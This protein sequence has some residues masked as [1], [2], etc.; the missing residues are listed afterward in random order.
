[1]EAFAV[2][3]ATGLLP[4]KSGFRQQANFCSIVALTPDTKL[5][6]F[7]GMCSDLTPY[8]PLL[9]ITT[10]IIREDKQGFYGGK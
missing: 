2:L 6:G 8:I 4:A 10:S 7:G 5:R 3:L 9:I 1:V